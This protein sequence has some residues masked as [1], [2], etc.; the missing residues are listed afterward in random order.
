MFMSTLGFPANFHVRTD[1]HFSAVRKVSMRMIV[2]DVFRQNGPRRLDRYARLASI[3]LMQQQVEY[4]ACS[5]AW[6][7]LRINDPRWHTG[8]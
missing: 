8:G 4:T 1:R 5:L 6:F 2:I 7:T 3:I